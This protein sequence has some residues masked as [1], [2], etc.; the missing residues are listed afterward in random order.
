[1]MGT[2]HSSDILITAKMLQ[3]QLTSQRV[4][5]FSPFG[6]TV[7]IITRQSGSP[8][9]IQ[10][11]IIQIIHWKTAGFGLKNR[12]CLTQIMSGGKKHQEHKRLILRRI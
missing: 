10:K 8:Q 4:G 6:E 5:G 1:M 2:Q 11:L 7:I 12:R 3:Q 9:A